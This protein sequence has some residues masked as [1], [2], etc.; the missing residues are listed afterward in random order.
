MAGDLSTQVE[1]F[2]LNSSTWPAFIAYFTLINPLIEEYFW[3]G[4]LGNST[5]GFS[6]SDLL[7]AGYHALILIDKVQIGSIIY[8]LIALVTAGWL[9]RQIA[10]EDHGLLAPVLG[11]MAADLTII[12][13]IYW[14]I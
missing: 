1:S 2:G 12:L 6:V 7:Y 5:K 3:R 11:H 14:K 4:Y 10:R 8:A 13:A 9:W